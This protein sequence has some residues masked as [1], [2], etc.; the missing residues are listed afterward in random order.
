VNSP[1]LHRLTTL[2]GR[3][4][5]SSIALASRQ[6]AQVIWIHVPV[7]RKRTP[8]TKLSE[9]ELHVCAMLEKRT[10]IGLI[11]AY[12]VAMKHFLRGETGIFYE[13][14]FPLV[15][16]LP[17]YVASPSQSYVHPSPSKSSTPGPGGSTSTSTTTQKDPP[18]TDQLPLW[19]HAEP[20][21]PFKKR[22]LTRAKTFEP[23]KLLPTISTDAP[24]RPARNPPKTT[25]WEFLPFLI[26]FR[27]LAKAMSRRVRAAIA[28]SGE[29]RGISGKVRKPVKV[30][31]NVPLEITLFLSSYLSFL[32]KN[33]LLQAAL[34]TAYANQMQALQDCASVLFL[35]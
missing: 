22:P 33:G 8:E 32:L 5:W 16:F 2:L 31:S 24:L 28:D 12:S 30:E 13:D 10:M 19:F 11:Q 3:K 25:I 4:L 17:R 6:L 14:L 9:T 1:P 27:W 18:N 23:E 34:A 20:S 7:D 35:C 15:A 21:K 29:D 26:P